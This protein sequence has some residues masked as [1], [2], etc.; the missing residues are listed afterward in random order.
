MRDEPI[1]G[2]FVR[3]GPAAQRHRTGAKLSNHFLPS[4]GGG[5]GMVHIDGVETQA[6]GK[7]PLIV[8]GDTVQ[9]EECS[10]WGSGTW[11][12]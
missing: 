10:P 1:A 7:E 2:G 8:A 3:S 9:I 5:G 12:A 11:T 6:C 4:V